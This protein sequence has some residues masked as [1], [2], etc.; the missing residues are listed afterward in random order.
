M[1]VKLLSH[2]SHGDLKGAVH[3]Q[4]DLLQVLEEMSPLIQKVSSVLT[5]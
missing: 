1:S 4:L 3:W 2:P 5:D